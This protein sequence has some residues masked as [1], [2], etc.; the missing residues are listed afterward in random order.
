MKTRLRTMLHFVFDETEKMFLVHTTGMVN[1]CVDLPDVVE[2]SV[3][4]C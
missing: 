3:K 1:M 4:A 2:V